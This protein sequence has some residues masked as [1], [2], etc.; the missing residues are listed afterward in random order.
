MMQLCNIKQKQ[1]DRVFVCLFFK[2]E[3]V[4]ANQQC[5]STRSPVEVMYL[6]QYCYQ[7][8]CFGEFVLLEF[9]SNYTAHKKTG[10]IASGQAH[11]D[12]KHNLLLKATLT[13]TFLP[14][15]PAVAHVFTSHEFVGAEVANVSPWV[16]TF[17]FRQLQEFQ[18]CNYLISS[19][20]IFHHNCLLT[21]AR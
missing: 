12:E 17:F 14:L 15:M 9:P 7:T 18:L 13:S 8:I 3:F 4:D 1:G 5:A 21:R 11:A 16:C 19:L 20:F 10:F 6:F 2:L